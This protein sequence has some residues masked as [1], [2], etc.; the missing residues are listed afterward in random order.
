MCGKFTAMASWRE[1]VEFS[2]HIRG[3]P[4]GADG[5]DEDV[6]YGVARALPV[7]VWAREARKRLAIPMRWGFPHPKDWRRPQP[8]HA[9]SETIDMTRA[10]AEAF[11]AGQRGIVVFKTFNEGE[12]VAKPSGKTETVQWTVDPRDGQ[13]RGFAF[14]WQRFE[15]PDLPQPMIACVMATV[16]ANK[17]LRESILKNDPD[18]R[19]PAILEDSDW[20]TWLG[21]NDAAPEQAK[22]VLR[23]MEGVN[24]QLAPEPKKAKTGKNPAPDKPRPASGLF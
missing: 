4:K 6:T 1:V 5:G 17:L 14:L 13:P 11:A 15:I 16:S 21:E 20:A 2:Q 9:R 12:E 7:I 8:I 24:W 3:K 19:M 10:F 23:T 22:E 18:P